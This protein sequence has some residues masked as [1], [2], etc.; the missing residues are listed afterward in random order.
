MSQKQSGLSPLRVFLAAFVLTLMAAGVVVGL[1][2]L[3]NSAR[4]TLS[5]EY[6]N[7]LEPPRALTDFTLQSTQGGDISL[8]DLKGRY[9]L[10]TF[11]YTFCP[12]VC[13]LTLTEFRRVKRELGDEL[14]ANVNF[15]FVSVDGERDTPELLA[16]YVTRFDPQFIG[17]TTPDEPLMRSITEQ[18]GVYFEFRAI[19]NTQAAYIVDHTATIFLL[20]PQGEIVALYPFGTPAQ[21]IANDLKPL[22]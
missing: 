14:A 15:T 21:A 8:S 11:G 6:G 5:S 10:V 17:M 20:N 16:Q 19:E 12:D 1:N 18:F 2:L 22:L 3:R 7:L 9:S 13:P 4:L